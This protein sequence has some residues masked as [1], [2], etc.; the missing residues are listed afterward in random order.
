MSRTSIP[1][2]LQFPLL[3]FLSLIHLHFIPGLANDPSSTKNENKAASHGASSGSV[4]LKVVIVCLGL[5]VFVG[6]AVLVFKI[7]K[8]K[9]REEQHARLLKLFE[10]D[11]ELDVE[12]GIRD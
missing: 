2:S 9:K 12:L 6:F 10:D 8:K 7:W 1:R 11:D 4:G 5:V 3:L